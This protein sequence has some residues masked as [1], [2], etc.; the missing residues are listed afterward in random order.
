MLVH[1]TLRDAPY[2]QE[3][4]ENNDWNIGSKSNEAETRR[5]R[6]KGRRALRED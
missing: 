2:T 1:L 3:D 6:Y 5:Q 4:D